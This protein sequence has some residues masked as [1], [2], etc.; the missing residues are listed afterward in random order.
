MIPYTTIATVNPL[1][2]YSEYEL[3]EDELA[4]MVTLTEDGYEQEALD[5]FLDEF[6]QPAATKYKDIMTN[7]LSELNAGPMRDKEQDNLIRSISLL[8]LGLSSFLSDNFKTFIKNVYAENVFD[9]AEIT[10]SE[11]KRNIQK[12]VIAEFEQLIGATMSQTQSFILNS[13][14]TLQREMVAENLFLKNS[15]ISGEAL[16]A[17]I[18]RFKEALQVK[19]PGI[20]KA[21]RQGNLMTTVKFSDGQELTRHYK[22]DYYIDLTVRTTLLNVDRN[23]NMTA[24]LINGERVMEFYLADNRNVQK[25]RE[26]CQHI[27]ADK[28][29]GLSI[30]ALDEATAK[31]LGIMTVDEAKST[32]DWAFGAMC[33]HSL[34]RCNGQY[35]SSINMLLGE[36]K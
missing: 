14:R 31:R 25:D 17:E 18:I 16:E 4:L 12:E 21:M 5:M 24:A 19:Y 2:F 7:Y 33:R 15:D 30:L 10:D 32:P 3:S 23:A 8:S 36:N 26:I 28:I 27:L 20:Y 9:K 34:K 35:L 13:V 22:L 6:L 11:L 29:E 1:N